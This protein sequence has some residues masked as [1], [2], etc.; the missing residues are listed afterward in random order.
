MDFETFSCSFL[1]DCGGCSQGDQ[2]YLL[3]QE[4]KLNLTQK[5]FPQV[6]P[7]FHFLGTQGLRE[8]GDFIIHNN[9]F[10]LYSKQREGQQ[11]RQLIPIQEC[12]QLT[13][14]TQNI[15]TELQTLS[16]PIK[17]GS[18]RF[19]AAPL[20]GKYRAGLWL[21]FA[22]LD[23]KNLLESGA[24]LHSLL[25][26]NFYIEVGQKQKQVISIAGTLKLVEAELVPWS[27][28][29][30]EDQEV[31]LF[32]TVSSFTQTGRVANKKLASLLQDEL[33]P[34][35]RRKDHSHNQ[36]P[37]IVE[38]GSGIGTLTLPA[39]AQGRKV[40]CCEV[41][42][43][44]LEGLKKTIAHYKDQFLFSDRV[45]FLTGNFHKQQDEDFFENVDAIL[46]NP[47]RSGI[48]DFLKV[49][50]SV[51]SQKL[52]AHL[53]YL[54]CFIESMKKDSLFFESLGYQLQTMHVIDQFPQ[55]PHFELLGRWSLR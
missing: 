52:P 27:V 47:P 14:K 51:E 21:D 30:F 46:V 40:K 2:P 13:P 37:F 1:N 35:T 39:L 54:S 43:S 25:E 42:G 12:P 10:C 33:S 38:F 49:L 36:A 23:I 48:G 29:Y 32:S 45:L 15:L 28:T 4:A 19:R 8:R 24:L 26:K 22:N 18:I 34:A 50:E 20:G 55:S 6:S 7:Q 11:Q 17:K 41:E 44:A 16:W 3:Q 9:A 31:G 5:N 53:I